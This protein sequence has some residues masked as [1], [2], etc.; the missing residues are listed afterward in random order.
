ML[1]QY[2]IKKLVSQCCFPFMQR[3]SQVQMVAS[4]LVNKRM[5]YFLEYL[6]STFGDCTRQFLH[7]SQIEL[8]FHIHMY[9]SP[10]HLTLMILC[11]CVTISQQDPISELIL[12]FRFGGFFAEKKQQTNKTHQ[13]KTIFTK[14]VTCS[15]SLSLDFQ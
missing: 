1:F 15:S 12:V 11:N 13:P 2:D 5:D 10:L 4:L 9:F 6:Y 8:I 14:K 7:I 3:F